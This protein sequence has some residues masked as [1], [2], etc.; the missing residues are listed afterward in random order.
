VSRKV[1]SEAAET[2]A[3]E[4]GS[5]YCSSWLA[6]LLYFLHC[7][8]LAF[9][10]DTCRSSFFLLPLASFLLHGMR[11]N[12]VSYENYLMSQI[13]TEAEWFHHD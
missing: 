8:A 7:K 5:E 13:F 11:L 6:T 3:N 1:A 10:V 4:G 2:E 9:G 12:Y